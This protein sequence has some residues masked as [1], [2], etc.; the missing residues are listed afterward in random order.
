MI[1]IESL[2]NGRFKSIP[3][4]C[5][6][7]AS[8][9]SALAMSVCRETGGE[10]CSMDSM[11]IYR[12]MDIGTAKPTLEEQRLVRHHLIDIADPADNYNTALYRN[13]ALESIRD[14]LGRGVLPVFCGG[15][16]QYA[17]ALSQ[18]ITFAPVEID[19]DLHES[20]LRESEEAGIQALYEELVSV[21]PK[22]AEKI[23]PNN[24]KRVIRALEIYRQTG[25]TMDYFN[26]VSKKDGPVYPFSL[27]AINMDREQ[28]Y[29]RM[30]ERVD[31]MLEDGLLEEVIRLRKDGLN[32]THTAMQA[33]GYKEL[34]EYLEG[35][36]PLADAAAL[37]KQKTRNYGKRQL[38]WFRS[39]ENVKWIEPQD[40][41]SVLK[42]ITNSKI[43]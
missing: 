24:R 7:T 33:I 36:I 37:I 22:S 38:T 11:Q 13:A 2:T 31:R 8:G 34:Y 39:M 40:V 12:N 3:I 20:L 6:P 10:L 16:G 25:K 9:K 26:S 15:T 14:C 29:R 35:N 28:L 27:F 32:R 18:G 42:A 19:P 23:H 17:S 21:D 43:L 5:G 4:I 1:P 41:T 30:D